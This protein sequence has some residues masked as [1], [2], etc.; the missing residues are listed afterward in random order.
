MVLDQ[1][2]KLDLPR[3]LI[4][5]L[6]RKGRENR[7]HRADND[8]DRIRQLRAQR[9]T[10]E[11]RLRR[12]AL[13]YARSL[14]DDELYGLEHQGLRQAMQLTEWMLKNPL[15]DSGQLRGNAA[16]LR[17]MDTFD[18]QFGSDD[19]V[20]RNDALLAV[21]ESVMPT[22]HGVDVILKPVWRELLDRIS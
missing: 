13:E 15:D 17:I 1:V 10:L 6:K 5:V 20:K 12:L 8:A 2:R 19:V 22:V 21:V 11:D 18:E 9:R 4:P 3:K 16:L 14:I 7:R